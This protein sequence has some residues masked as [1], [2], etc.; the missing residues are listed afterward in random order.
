MLKLLTILSLYWKNNEAEE[1]ETVSPDNSIYINYDKQTQDYYIIWEPVIV[2]MGKTVPATME[3]LRQ[4]LN[5]DLDTLEQDYLKP[6]SP[7][8]DRQ[9]I[10]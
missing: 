4:A 3:D 5:L 7:A 6:S 10:T 1:T 8:A 9:R 2:G